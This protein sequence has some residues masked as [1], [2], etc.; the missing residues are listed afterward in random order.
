LEPI[1]LPSEYRVAA[2]KSSTWDRISTGYPY[3][4]RL[5]LDCMLLGM[6]LITLRIFSDPGITWHNTLGHAILDICCTLISGCIIYCFWVE[7]KVSTERRI[8]LAT[9]AFCGFAV[10]KLVEGL[11]LLI[12]S[13]DSLWLQRIAWEYSLVWQVGGAL[14]LIAAARNNQRDNRQSCCRIGLR[15]IISSMILSVLATMIIV[16]LSEIWPRVLTVFPVIKLLRHIYSPFLSSIFTIQVLP[17]IAFSVALWVFA[18]RHIK[19]EDPFSDGIV[20]CLLLIICSQAALRMSSVRYDLLWWSAPLLDIGALLALLMKLGSE[21]GAS[22]AD[23]RD[24]IEH[25]E[26]VHYISSRLSSTLDLRVVLLALVSDAAGMLSARFAS[27]MLADDAGEN[28]TTV[29]TFGLP[30]M[31]LNP[32]KP[33]PTQGT[34]RPGF[35]S[36]HTAKAFR[37]KRVCVVDDVYTDVEFVP[38]RLLSEHDGYSVSVPLIYHDVALGVID[39]FFD[40]HVPLNDERVK[41]FQTLASAAAA[42][43]ANAQLYERSLQYQQQLADTSIGHLRL[44]IAS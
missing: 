1:H 23:A 44:D 37:E 31:P 18:R 28:L 38:W 34:G 3:V 35:Y 4:I 41:L 33:Q 12:N 11:S 8:L 14:L 7:Y 42:A 17:L 36:G 6:L 39:L 21:F 24:R 5:A 32:R 26:A 27:I 16:G 22:Y 13:G 15:M 2:A 9:I 25:L 43:I 30:E 10:G 19:E 40:K 20:R 29:A